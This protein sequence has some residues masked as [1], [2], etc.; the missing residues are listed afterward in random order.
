MEVGVGRREGPE[1]EGGLV[2]GIQVATKVVVVVVVV[3]VEEAALASTARSVGGEQDDEWSE[4][5]VGQSQL[6]NHRWPEA[7]RWLVEEWSCRLV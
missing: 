6:W 1:D 3:V 4:L 7:R 5:H 2:R